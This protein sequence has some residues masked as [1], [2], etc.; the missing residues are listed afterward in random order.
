[1]TYE[2]I[3]TII[4]TILV[5]MS[6]LL[7]WSIWTYQ[8]KYETMENTKTVPEVSISEQKD[9]KQIIK[10]D[11]IFYHQADSHY[12]TINTGEIDRVIKELSKWNFDHLE[13]VTEQINNLATFPYESGHA[14]IVFPD[15]I[16]MDI[17]KNILG[18]KDNDANKIKFDQIVIEM[19]NISKESG[20]VY[21]ISFENQQVH[22]ARVT[23]SFVTN[24]EED[25]FQ[26][27]SSNQ[28]FVKYSLETISGNKKILV[29]H[30]PVKMFAYNYLL[31]PLP[32]SKFKDALFRNPSFVKRNSNGSVEEYKDST[33]LLS[34]NYDTNTILYVNPAQETE[35]LGDTTNLLQKS[36]DFVNGHGGWTDNYHYVGIAENEQ[37]VQFRLYD[38][39]GYPVFNNSGMS[40]ILQ[41]WGQTGIYQY[42]RNNFSLERRVEST[43]IELPSGVEALNLLKNMKDFDIEFIQDMVL[44]YEMTRDLNGPLIH[45]GPAWYY[46]YK[47]QWWLLSPEKKGG[48]EYG[49]E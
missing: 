13:D 18:F 24:F 16:P 25:F 19:N 9:I 43:E 41:I 33:T 36:I 32:T 26:K 5:V 7:T 20:F 46:K 34:V 4:L 8:P 22:R 14:Q 39:A 15:I 30:D 6:I 27:A 31:D 49:L 47:D 12:G 38:S 40:E 10:P 28:F 42:M 11:K 44:G 45:L 21:F 3:K 23:S 1:M 48:P 17:Y 29:N 37:T 2:N 35:A